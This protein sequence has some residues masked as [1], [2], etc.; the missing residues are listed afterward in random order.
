MSPDAVQALPRTTTAPNDIH[1]AELVEMGSEVFVPDG[2]AEPKLPAE[3]ERI[4]FKI[5][6]VEYP[7]FIPILMRVA[8]RVK[9]WV[10][11]SLYRTVCLTGESTK[12]GVP[13]CSFD[14]FAGAVERMPH[15]FLRDAV[16]NM[17]LGHSPSIAHAQTILAACTKVTNLALT[18]PLSLQDVPAL[19]DLKPT[20]LTLR[21]DF[22][23]GSI[24]LD[25]RHSIF[26]SITHLELFDGSTKYRS[27]EW[28]R[29]VV[30]IP[31]LTHLALHTQL[32]A[33][34]LMPVLPTCARLECVVFAGHASRHPLAHN[35][36]VRFVVAKSNIPVDWLAGARGAD[37]HWTRAEVVIAARRARSLRIDDLSMSM[38][39]F[40]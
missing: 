40:G 18:T 14:V 29:I 39:V 25:F 5:C 26:G 9:H 7:A 33:T 31:H 16:R 36:D 21:C 34:I 13:H 32:L 17:Y 35:T 22:L 38:G 12:N 37:D 8:W 4:I 19:K 15:N 20:R 24:P 6:A 27:F 11:P 3:L 2:T 1:P 23:F 10:E 30:D 28:E